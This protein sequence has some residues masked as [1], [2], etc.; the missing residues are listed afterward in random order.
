M[1]PPRDR[2]VDVHLVSRQQKAVQN[3]HDKKIMSLSLR[4]LL[5]KHASY[6]GLLSNTSVHQKVARASE[7]DF[8]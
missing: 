4:A 6:R 1:E 7:C 3:L 2:V 8:N 5:Q